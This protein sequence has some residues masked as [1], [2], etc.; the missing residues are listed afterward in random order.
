[1]QKIEFTGLRDQKVRLRHEIDA[2][3]MRVLDHGQFILGPEVRDF[4][5]A[6]TEYCGARH[7]IG[8]ANGTD[9]LQICLMTEGIGPG[10]AVLV[11]SFT[12]TAT[13]E[14][15]LVLGAE[16]VFVD[17]DIATFNMDAADLPRALTEAQSRGLRPRAIIGVDLFGLPADWVAINA[18]AEAHGLAVIA[19]AAQGF[20]AITAQGAHVGT[21]A[22]Y[23]TT[24]FFPAKPLG[25]YGDGGAVFTDDD[26]LAAAMRSIRVHGQGKAKYETVRVGLNSRLDTLQAAILL[27][28]ISVFREETERRNSL[29]DYFSTQLRA[30]L[31][32]PEKPAGVTSAWAQY[33]LRVPQRDAVQLALSEAGVPTAI[34][35]P[36]PMHLQPAYAA[37]GRGKGSLQVSEKLSGEVLSLPMNPYCTPEQASGLWR[38]WSTRLSPLSLPRSSQSASSFSSTVGGKMTEGQVETLYA[39]ITDKS[40]VIGLIGMGYVGLPLWR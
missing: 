5:A 30:H 38:R 10:D 26:E 24:S 29:A 7:A 27:A 4:E 9:A 3:I 23:T 28:K 18:F 34:Y 32:V 33:T 15:I 19:D 20:G 16:P 11:P 2:R 14:V 6:L 37:Y 36:L 31:Q 13:A 25:C 8:C 17:V 35:Y 12:Y 39:K 1:M 40:A 21:L 22:R